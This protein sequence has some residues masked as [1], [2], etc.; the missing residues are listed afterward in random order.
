MKIQILMSTYNGEKY[1]KEQLDSILNQSLPVSSILIRDD[2]STDRTMEIL[3][4]Y[5]Q[6]YPQITYY[7][8]RNIGAAESFM[9][10]IGMAD[11]QMDY[12]AFS[13]QDDVWLPGKL[14]RAVSCLE[15]MQN[16]EVPLLYCSNTIPVDSQLHPLPTDSLPRNV[17]PSFGNA[18][19]QNINTGC[20]CVVNGALIRVA[21]HKHPKFVIMH[22]W[23]LYLIATCF[24]EVYWDSEAYIEYRQHVN[25]EVGAKASKSELWR[26]KFRNFCK[27]RGSIQRQNQ[28]FMEAFHP[29]GEKGQLLAMVAEQRQSFAERWRVIRTKEIYRQSKMDDRIFR[30]LYL[31]GLE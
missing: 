29:M 9:E 19:V 1:L 6:R 10:L 13:D 17:R 20:T 23:W 24:G 30:L 27:H 5:S 7:P 25:N 14:E 26:S 3:A 8:E 11:A 2:G 22:D 31:L 4:E 12:I 28:E 18:I 15:R 16:R 21:R